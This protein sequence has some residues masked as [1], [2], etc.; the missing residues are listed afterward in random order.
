MPDFRSFCT[1]STAEPVEL[2]LSPEESHHLV[3]VNRARIGDTVVA[4]DGRGTEWICELTADR[5]QAAVLKVRFKQK[6]KP[7]PYEITLGQALPKGP[8]MDAIVRKATEIGAACIVPIESERTQVHLD[9]E[10]SERK[11]EKWQTA[12]LEAAKQCG[13]AFLPAVLPVQKA[14]AFIEGARGY[15]LKL[16]A[17]LQPGAKSLKTVLAAFQAAHGRAPK[18]VLW[19]VGPEGDFTPAELSQSRSCGFEPI[20]LGP[21]VLRCETAAAYALSI[22]SYELQNAGFCPAKT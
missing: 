2:T 9:G 1:P 8:F 4:F 13:N 14:A 15:D 22:L 10:R 21:L 20:T 17:S 7:L 16:I 12:A 19:L 18:K 3:A 6:L 11:I 5:K